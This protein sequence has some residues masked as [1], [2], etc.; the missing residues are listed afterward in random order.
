[1]QLVSDPLPQS[2]SMRVGCLHAW[3]GNFTLCLMRLKPDLLLTW[4]SASCRLIRWNGF[5]LIL[6]AAAVRFTA[7]VS[8]GHLWAWRGNFT[9]TWLSQ[10]QLKPGLPLMWTWARCHLVGW[11]DWLVPETA[12]AGV[13][14]AASVN[15]G[16]LQA[17]CLQAWRGSLTLCL[18]WLRPGLLLKWTWA[19]CLKPDCSWCRVACQ[20]QFGSLWAWQG[21][22]TEP[23]AAEA[24]CAAYKN[25]SQLLSDQVTQL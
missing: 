8:V 19:G 21:N 6:S 11:R 16:C 9:L 22:Y 13:S 2:A 12:R 18:M 4:T 1:M 25:M 3:W 10:M 5:G 23:D 24:R 14:L 17:G 20:Y 7:K 15:V